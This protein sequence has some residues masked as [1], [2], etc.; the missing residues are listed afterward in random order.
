[1]AN[2]AFTASQGLS[3]SGMGRLMEG[4]STAHYRSGNGGRTWTCQAGHRAH[5]AFGDG[6]G[7][8][9][10]VCGSEP[11]R[12]PVHCYASCCVM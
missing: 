4:W 2:P 5:W 12:W 8:E 11:G 1:M 9:V 6:G 7:S 10:C 3:L